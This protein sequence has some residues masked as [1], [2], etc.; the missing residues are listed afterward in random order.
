MSQGKRKHHY[1]RTLRIAHLD[2]VGSG[3]CVLRTPKIVQNPIRSTDISSDTIWGTVNFGLG[4]TYTTTDGPTAYYAKT[5]G[6][7]PNTYLG[8]T[9]N[10]ISTFPST[11]FKLGANSYMGLNKVRIV[12]K[13][14]VTCISHVSSDVIRPH[15]D[16][17]FTATKPPVDAFRL[18]P[19]GFQGFDIYKIPETAWNRKDYEKFSY[20]YKYE[21]LFKSQEF[22]HSELPYEADNLSWVLK[23]K[24]DLILWPKFTFF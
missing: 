15:I 3:N 10:K 12:T 16:S 1:T 23:K 4:V 19:G 2:A 17:S 6:F 9:E 11:N 20:I 18:N 21:S 8:N 14:K 24:E 22:H 5:S 7:D 13:I